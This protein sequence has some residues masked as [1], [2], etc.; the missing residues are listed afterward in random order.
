MRVIDF[1][2]A[3]S[4]KR[5]VV[6]RRGWSLDLV[7]RGQPP[8]V[9]NLGNLY[10]SAS[11]IAENS[12][13]GTVVGAILG[14]RPA[15]TLTLVDS[16]GGRFAIAGANIVAAATA[17]N[18]ESATSHQIT[19]RET[20]PGSA[21]SPRDTVISIT[22]TNQFEQPN[23]SAISLSAAV[24]AEGSAAGSVV[25][26]L[27]GKTS[28][29]AVALVDDAG[30]RFAISEGNLVAGAT[31][32]DFETA[33]SHSVTLRETLADSANSP[34]DTVLW[35]TIGNVFEQPS[36]AAL[37][38]SSSTATV[39]T[40]T[41][42]SIIGATAGSTLAGAVPDGMTLN[43]A[44]RTITGTPTVAGTYNFT[45]TETLADSANSPRISNV[46]VTVAAPA[47]SAADFYMADTGT[48]DGLSPAAPGNF[49]TVW[50]AASDGKTIK[51][52]GDTTVP[53]SHVW[54]KSVTIFAD[55]GAAD[56]DPLGDGLP[57][58]N[59]RFTRPMKLKFSPPQTKGPL[60]TLSACISTVASGKTLT[61]RDGIK[62]VFEYW[63]SAGQTWAQHN[64]TFDG[65]A[66]LAKPLITG[67]D[68]T[69]GIVIDGAEVFHG[70]GPTFQPYDPA[71]KLAEFQSPAKFRINSDGTITEDAAGSYT[72]WGDPITTN[73]NT[74]FNGPLVLGGQ[75][76]LV[77]IKNGYFHDFREFSKLIISTTST[78][79][80]RD[81][82]FERSIGDFV[83]AQIASGSGQF[84]GT[85][86]FERNIVLDVI[87]NA[88]DASNPHSDATQLFAVS[89]TAG[90]DANNPFKIIR[91]EANNNFYGISRKGS[92]AQLQT[93]F[94]QASD[95]HQNTDK[96]LVDQGIVRNNVAIGLG[97]KLFYADASRD[98]YIRNNIGILPTW[99]TPPG[100]ANVCDI[101]VD[102]TY[103]TYAV[104][105]P[106]SEALV[107]ST[108]AE[109]IAGNATIR[110]DDNLTTGLQGSGISH[111]T[112]FTDPSDP[113]SGVFSPHT[114]F[115]KFKPLPAHATKGPQF[116][117]LRALIS[118]N[119]DFTGERPHIGPL[120]QIG[121][122]A[123]T[124]TTSNMFVIHGGD[125][126][127]LL[128]FVG[129]AGLEWRTLEPSDRSTV[130]TDWNSANANVQ[131]GKLMQFRMTS[132]AAGNA[133]T[134]TVSLGGSTFDWRLDSVTAYSYPQIV[135][136]PT[137][138][139]TFGPASSQTL[140]ASAGPVGTMAIMRFNMAD[141]PTANTTLF[142]SSAGTPR[143]QVQIL[144]TGQIRV[145]LAAVGTASAFARVESNFTGAVAGNGLCDGNDHDILIS[146]DTSQ[147]DQALGRSLY[148]DGASSNSSGALWATGTVGYATAI[149][150]YRIGNVG[151]G[152]Q[153][154]KLGAFILRCTERVD[155]TDGAKRALFAADYL[156]N[157]GLGPFSS[158][159]AFLLTG[160]AGQ[161]GGWN[162]AAT[163]M[164]WGTG[165][166]FKPLTTSAV[167]DVTGSAWS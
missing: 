52:V 23:L 155:I 117:S 25:G 141:K 64:L 43:S 47:G 122:A 79:H 89:A 19:I 111:A 121:V 15:S 134:K 150:S 139:D 166:K 96:A 154:I 35:I 151:S 68:Y 156:R 145:S 34:R 36:L 20:L 114:L 131:V 82:W 28:G 102:R 86:K 54:N 162:D 161:A 3:A 32:T 101:R 76:G 159:P 40:S 91:P 26:V 61:I 99:W 97:Y 105:Y 90:N 7:P 84:T 123:S 33:T 41:S 9:P 144:T 83:R 112:I 106:D 22:V 45:L 80:I 160:T 48:G 135:M 93:H 88:R 167:A 10:L 18:F 107:A 11:T 146:W 147:S 39:G 65:G 132:A 73:Y 49:A 140:A 71:V 72:G 115:E 158:R 103:T 133:V 108:I 136:D 6:V 31:S 63:P 120:D 126:G 94:W 27:V 98:M 149:N 57:L 92:R 46:S 70:Y 165:F 58:S 8:A 69:S 85:F 128:A 60:S 164:N 110:E 95:S 62:C 53:S 163:G 157:G 109:G 143:V 81:C 1:R 14:A 148:V 16:A 13:A 12:A 44:L 30:G 5:S 129:T 21:N 29:S 152:G 51:L 74:P 119:G 38:L 17:T 125:P 118:H 153:D 124:L 116:S 78:V 104:S 4:R 42:I 59:C 87:G 142:G 130:I 55:K 37:T 56:A 127:D 50:A 67:T 24:L 137:T 138:P 2:P 113:G 100:G 66:A 77:N 75:W